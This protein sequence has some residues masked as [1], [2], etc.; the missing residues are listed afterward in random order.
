MPPVIRRC[1][2]DML[3]QLWSQKL[4]CIQQHSPVQIA[5]VRLDI[6]VNE[7]AG[8]DGHPLAVV[9]FCAGAGGPTP[10]F[11]RL[12]NG[13]RENAGFP[14]LAFKMCD[15]RPNIPAWIEHC[16]N[17]DNLTY[18]LDP[19]DAA[20][21]PL[22]LT[23][24]KSPKIS[25]SQGPAQTSNAPAALTET[26]IFRLFNLSFHHFDDETAK[27]VLRSTLNHSDG[28]SII[29][30]QD[31]HIGSL[32]M[33]A[34]NWLLFLIITPFYFPPKNRKNII[35]N[36]LTYT[37]ILPFILCFD[38]LVSCLRTREFEDV[39]KLIASLNPSHAPPRI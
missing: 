34:F 23:G 26:R 1:C 11:E 33:I 29:E 22:H 4:Y 15:L 2:Q 20:N 16:K 28:F 24:I 3:Q 38:G 21:P 31:R 19:V 14:P 39:I 7:V 32:L 10:I 30:L 18:I 9:D 5:T 6:L 27:R 8:G 13:E 35:Q 17:S 25:F 37:L 36:I 12:I